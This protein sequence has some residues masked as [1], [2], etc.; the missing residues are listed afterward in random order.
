MQTRHLITVGFL[1]LAFSVDAA[2]A[3][4]WVQR[5]DQNS[6]VLLQVLAKYAPE[7]ASRFGV[8]GHDTDV[9]TLP[10]DV[11]A[12]TVADLDADIQQLEAKLATEKEPS[13]RQ[14]LQILTN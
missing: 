6:A 5:S 4:E 14:D 11:N 9:T 2:P 13:V 7:T 1:S 8:E 12:R 10:L 3:P